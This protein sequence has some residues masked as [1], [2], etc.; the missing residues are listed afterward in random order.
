M[1]CI[2]IEGIGW[3]IIMNRYELK[4]YGVLGMKWGVRKDRISSNKHRL[5]D[6]ILVKKGTTISRIIPKEWE[7]R[8]LNLAGRAYASFK[9][10]DVAK[11][12][13]F[14]K[15]LGGE[16][17]YVRL[18]FKVKDVLVSPGEKKRIDEF[19]KLMSKDESALSVFKKSSPFLF[20]P[21]ERLA[22]LTRQKDIDNAYRRFS[23]LLVA[24]PELREKYINELKKQGYSMIIDDADRLGKISMSPVIIF[25]R[26]KSLTTPIVRRPK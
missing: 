16:S 21:K 25:D 26:E 17:S 14:A 7:K 15:M 8:E 24:K 23:Y 4:H 19:I 22:N 18:D 3:V 9:P 1:L 20:I 11:Y 10:E 12:E 6:D 13:K 5:S 2:Y